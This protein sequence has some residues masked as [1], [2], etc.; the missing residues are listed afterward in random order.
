MGK[1]NKIFV[2][3]NISVHFFNE[4]NAKFMQLKF[5]SSDFILRILFIGFYSSDYAELSED[6]LASRITHGI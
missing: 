4:F 5:S 1:G 2:I 3:P 6:I